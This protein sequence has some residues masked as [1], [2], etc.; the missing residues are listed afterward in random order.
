MSMFRII[1]ESVLDAPSNL[2]VAKR[3][4]VPPKQDSDRHII[5]TEIRSIQCDSSVF[6]VSSPLS[7]GI[8]E[9]N[10]EQVLRI[11]TTE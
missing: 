6:S 10:D 8:E 7:N 4:V 1:Y 11:L 9:S 5:N 3:S 2:L